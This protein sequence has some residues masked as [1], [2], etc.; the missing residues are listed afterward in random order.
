V[1]AL[2]TLVAFQVS[3]PDVAALKEMID[4]EKAFSDYCG[5]VGVRDSFLKYFSHDAI[6]F[7]KGPTKAYDSLQKRSPETGKPSEIL[8]WY[9][10]SGQMSAGGDLGYS[11]GPY[12]LESKGKRNWCGTFFSIWR[13][14]KSGELR[15]VLNVGSEIEPRDPAETP[16]YFVQISAA[17]RSRGTDLTVK[18]L[19][20]TEQGFGKLAISKGLRDAYRE[21]GTGTTRHLRPGFLATPFLPAKLEKVDSW[22]PVA[23]ETNAADDFAYTYGTFENDT[24]EKCF[25]HV[26]QREARGT[27]KLI[28]EVFH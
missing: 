7:D 28:F 27:W 1:F 8:S 6:T 11:T 2:L 10:A 23:Y 22:S 12:F 5:E 14:E 24:P 16:K 3:T 26:W 18:D 13:R 17:D 20:A 15:V 9:S 19:R 25:V 4:T 21:Y